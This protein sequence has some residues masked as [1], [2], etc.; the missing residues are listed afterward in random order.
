MRKPEGTP[1]ARPARVISQPGLRLEG[2][3]A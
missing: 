3:P 1:M 2:S